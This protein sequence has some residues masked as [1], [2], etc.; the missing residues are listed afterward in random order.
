[1]FPY[2]LKVHQDECGR[3]LVFCVNHFG[4][5]GIRWDIVWADEDG[6]SWAKLT[7]REEQDLTWLLLNRK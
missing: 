5:S 1:M 7:F 2:E 4:H 6:E 3:L